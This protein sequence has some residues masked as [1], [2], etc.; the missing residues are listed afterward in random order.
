M[1]HYEII[2]VPI[3]TELNFGPSE[4][5]ETLGVVQRPIR[6]QIIGP[7]TE[8]AYP[9]NLIDEQPPLNQ[10]RIYWHQPPPK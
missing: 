10:Q 8:G 4:D 9:I 3:G 5:S 2:S 7:L 6:A 1:T